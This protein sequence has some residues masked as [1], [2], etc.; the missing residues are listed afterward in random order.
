MEE[1]KDIPGYFGLY[2]ISNMGRIMRVP[3]WDVVK[4]SEIVKG[5]IRHYER[6][7]IVKLRILKPSI[8]RD[9]YHRISLSKNGKAKI[10]TVHRL[11]V[12]AF[13]PNPEN[14]P[15]IDHIN[16]NKQDNRVENLRWVTHKENINNPITLERFRKAIKTKKK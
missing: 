3:G 12:M 5:K 1:W 15:E 4:G 8:D 10:F 6:Q 14:K 13:I 9:G 7:R 2:I 11:V 16:G